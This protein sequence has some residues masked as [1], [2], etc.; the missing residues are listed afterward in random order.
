[1]ASLAKVLAENVNHCGPPRHN[2]IAMQH[3]SI[4]EWDK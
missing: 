4:F 1:M 3:T 2:L